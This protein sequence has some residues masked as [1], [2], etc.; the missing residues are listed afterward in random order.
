MLVLSRKKN[1]SIM[2]NDDIT[3]VIVDVG[4]GKV[5]LGIQAPE[6]TTIHRKEVWDSI[7]REGERRG[8]RT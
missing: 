7:K 5:Q 1:E 2:I 8:R 6:A 4:G 3:I